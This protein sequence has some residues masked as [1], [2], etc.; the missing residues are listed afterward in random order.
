MSAGQVIDAQG[1]DAEKQRI[2]EEF[3]LFE[4]WVSRYEYIV[5]LAGRLPP[6]PDSLKTEEN[7]VHGCQSRVWFHAD[8]QGGLIHFRADS[9]ATIVKGLIVLLLR[10]YSGRRPE[11]ILATPPTFFE[12]IELGSHLT[13]S[14][15][16]GLHAMVRR[17]QAT[18]LAAQSRAKEAPPIH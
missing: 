6:L 14:R 16:N 17:I 4:D 5:E 11:E 8:E 9:D 10:V 2:I 12:T 18:A 15:A 3:S 7:R 13:G 1:I